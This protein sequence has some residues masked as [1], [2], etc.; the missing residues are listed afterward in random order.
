MRVLWGLLAIV[1]GALGGCSDRPSGTGVYH[2]RS[3]LDW[4]D[5]DSDRLDRSKVD[6]I[7][8]RLFDWGSRGEVG[9]LVVRKSI[10]ARW[11]V[12]PVVYVTVDRLESWASD[13]KLVAARAAR[14]LLDHEDAVL[15]RAWPGRPQVWQLDADWSVKTRASW[16]AVVRAFGEL[17]HQRGGR[18]EVTVRLHQVKDRA[19]QGVPP[20][21]GGVLML[22][23][24]GDAILD[25]DLVEA[26]LRGDPYPLPLTPA[27]PVYGQVRQYNGYGRLVALTRWAGDELPL[28]HLRPVGPARWEVQGRVSWGGRILLAHDQIAVDRVEAAT[29]AKVAALAAVRAAR[30]S[31][32]GRIWVFDD[33]PHGWDAWV[34]G[35]GADV[36]FPR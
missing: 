28:D 25:P 34:A 29:L 2:W 20:A 27:F 12:V 33:D 13:P 6:V 22:Y 5:A 21:D 4:S 26:Y 23:G 15:S 30:Q 24:T 18:V 9:S 8:L 32:G 31:A 11:A 7:G 3:V 36:L 17:V 16:F 19:T 35:P 10:P 1:C 14:E